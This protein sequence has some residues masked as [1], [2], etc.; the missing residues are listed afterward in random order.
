MRLLAIVFSI[1]VVLFLGCSSP[2][3]STD[4]TVA[5]GT[6]NIE[7]LGDGVDDMK[8]RTDQE[9][10]LI[11]DII[12]RSG[13]DV[14][15]VQE[16]E[17]EDALKRVLRY[18]EGFDGFVYDAGIKQNVGVVYKK[19]VEVRLVGPYTALTVGR[20]RLRPGIVVQCK[21]GSFDWLMMVV[22]LKSTSRADSTNELR[23]ESR[24]IR[25]EQAGLLAR[26][27][28]S[29]VAGGSE[30][31]VMIV[32]DLNDFP[33]RRQ[34]GTLGPIM[35]SSELTILTSALKSCKTEGWMTIDH[36]VVS[37]SAN[38]RVIKGSEHVENIRA[39]LKPSLADAVS[40]HCPV[41]VRFSTQGPDND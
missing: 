15:G 16:I 29:V 24:K 12:A 36:V 17:N 25:M 18:L 34:Q 40:D 5:V 6:F 14:L 7:W 33:G 39:F 32:G 10:L 31:D 30:K 20:A 11:A 35:E 26:W 8:P 21:K 38:T 4:L 13:A 37:K 1:V 27:T 41:I 3:G 2:Q 19:N 22:H 28:D 9:C 23:D